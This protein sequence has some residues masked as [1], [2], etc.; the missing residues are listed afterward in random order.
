MIILGKNGHN[1]KVPC[2]ADHVDIWSLL[3]KYLLK[4]PPLNYALV[5]RWIL[6]LPRG[7]LALYDCD[8]A[9]NTRGDVHRLMFHH[10]IGAVAFVP[11]MPNATAWVPVSPLKVGLLAGLSTPFARSSFAAGI[12]LGF[13]ASRTPRPWLAC[14][15]SLLTHLAYGGGLYIQPLMMSARR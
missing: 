15:L 2:H 10:L 14:L 5:G 3:Q 11:L 1:R 6:R 9:A 4:V 8:N 7:V 12:G 13:A